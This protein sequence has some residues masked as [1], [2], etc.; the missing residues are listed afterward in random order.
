MNNTPINRGV[1]LFLLGVL[2]VAVALLSSTTEARRSR[3][4]G[5]FIKR[6]AAAARA[7]H[8]IHRHVHHHPRIHI[9]RHRHIPKHHRPIRAIVDK[10]VKLGRRHRKRL[11]RRSRRRG[12]RKNNNNQEGNE[13]QLPAEEQPPK[14]EQPPQVPVPATTMKKCQAIGDPHYT[15]FQGKYY[16]FYGVGDYILASSKDGDFVVHSRTGRWGSVSVNTAF[17]VKVNQRNTIE[18]DIESNTF[19]V[20]G[21]TAQVTQ[22]E[23][24]SLGSG[25]VAKRTSENSMTVSAKNGAHLIATWYRNP[26]WKSSQGSFG[27]ISLVV[28]APS[29]LE[30][31]SGL[32]VDKSFMSQTATGIL[33]NHVERKVVR[34]QK[35]KKPTKEEVQAAIKVCR[36]A[37]LKGKKHPLALRACV[38][39]QVQTGAKVGKSIAK[40]IK[41]VE[42]IADKKKKKW[43]RQ[44]DQR[45]ERKGKRVVKSTRPKILQKC[46]ALGDPH[47]TNF[48]GQYYDFYGVGDYILASSKDGDFVVH[49]RT[50]RWGSVSVNTAFAVKVNNLNTVE[51]NVETNSFYVNGKKSEVP[52]NEDIT[53]GDNAVAK[54]TAENSIRISAKNGAHLIATWYRNPS[55]KQ[56]QGSFG[57]ISLVVEAP[58]DVLFNAGLCVDKS[59]ISQKATGLLHDHIERQIE[60]SQKPRKPT[61]EEVQAAIKVCRKA[62]LKGKKHPL[63]LR[64]CVS[65]QVQ[66][67]AKVGKS[68]AKVIKQVERIADKKEKKWARKAKKSRKGKRSS[69][70]GSK[71]KRSTTG[72]KKSGKKSRTTRKQRRSS[73]TKR[74]S[75]NKRRSN[76]RSSS[77]RRSSNRRRGGA[78]RRRTSSRTR[79]AQRRSRRIQRRAA[80]EAARQQRLARRRAQRRARRARRQQRRAAR[81]QRK[82][83]QQRKLARKQRQQQKRA[84]RKQR[85]QKRRTARKQ[86]RVLKKLAKKAKKQ[87]R[88]NRKLAKKAKKQARKVARRAAR[89][90]RRRIQRRKRSLIKKLRRRLANRKLKRAAR[91]AARRARKLA[92][93]ARKLFKRAL[94]KGTRKAIA[95]AKCSRRLARKARRLARK[96]SR[97]IAKSQRK[98]KKQIRK[99]KR[100]A[101]KAVKKASKKA[102][103]TAK[104]RFLR[105][106]AFR[107]KLKKQVRRAASTVVQ[108]R[109]VR[110]I[111]ALLRKAAAI[112]RKYGKKFNPRKHLP[113]KL[114][115]LIKKLKLSLKCAVRRKKGPKVTTLGK[116]LVKNLIRVA[117]CARRK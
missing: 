26:S 71:K 113:K 96:L 57:H 75:S 40:V 72:K 95:R 52:I 5:N 97:K 23:D 11:A 21:Q 6:A 76:K 62:G 61:K 35:P 82:L 99:I 84:A 105:R 31:N 104:K 17:A 80:R 58:R 81:K 28:E 56:S 14:E 22:G 64:A 53:L 108:R 10:I 41:Q 20:N 85:K 101:K 102:A 27:H 30:F 117:R 36:K 70:T 42:R 47:Y 87:A 48:K 7:H 39:D 83:R 13:Q 94:K 55:W 89:R 77:K 110:K 106:I 8:H 43:A 34:S 107:N 15:D 60:R 98:I 2:C 44:V 37:G 66:T 73:S 103:K 49:S 33:H 111:K 38:S 45:N 9:R 4:G 92:R 16:D 65:D 114:V 91:R 100:A 19:Y 68:I 54:R 115:L 59:Y 86:K 112:R 74:R 116:R 29:N 12:G 51:Y 50:G 78:S 25:A 90:A 69:S 1:F 79:Q 63:A 18:F 109:T 88:R 67:G 24:F 46:Q 93:K 3:R 32:C